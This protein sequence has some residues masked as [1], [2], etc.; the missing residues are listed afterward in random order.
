MNELDNLDPEDVL[1]LADSRTGLVGLAAD[2]SILAAGGAQEPRS[3]P[4]PPTTT[5]AWPQA[6]RI[7]L[8]AGI[9]DLSA[10]PHHRMY[11]LRTGAGW[12]D[13]QAVEW[14]DNGE[15]RRILDQ[16]TRSGWSWACMQ[17]GAPRV[18]VVT[19]LAMIG[20]SA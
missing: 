13:G 10:V 4:A 12:V 15:H 11:G 19:H 14:K 16:A 7:D 20:G 18:V 6:F 17:Q 9:V 5:S 8:R 1:P 2:R 3:A